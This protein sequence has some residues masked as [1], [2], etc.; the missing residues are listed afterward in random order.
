MYDDGFGCAQ[1]S[2]KAMKYITSAADQG[3]MQSQELLGN[4]KDG[5]ERGGGWGGAIRSEREGR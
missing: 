4:P 3:F 1:D 2:V 5:R